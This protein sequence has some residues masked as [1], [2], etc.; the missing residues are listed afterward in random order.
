MIRCQLKRAHHEEQVFCITFTMAQS[1]TSL[2]MHNSTSNYTLKSWNHLTAPESLLESGRGYYN[3]W[4]WGK[5][6]AWKWATTQCCVQNVFFFL[7]QAPA[8]EFA[9]CSITRVCNLLRSDCSFA[10]SALFVLTSITA[11]LWRLQKYLQ[12]PTAV[13]S[14]TT[15]WM[16]KTCFL[17][18]F[19]F[20]AC[21]LQLLCFIW[22]DDG[23]LFLVCLWLRYSKDSLECVTVILSFL[24][25]STFD[26]FPVQCRVDEKLDF[27]LLQSVW[28]S[29]G[30]TF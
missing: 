8:L 24:S 19:H 22:F 9:L 12:L 4:Q 5:V 23:V 6:I 3:C 2:F 30:C 16:T 7:S 10:I 21:L 28:E 1:W 13:V 18:G 14:G 20:P 11:W 25:I 26:L 17:L 15:G 27:N 29:D